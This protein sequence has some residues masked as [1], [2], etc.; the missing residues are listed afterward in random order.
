MWSEAVAR[1]HTSTT[2]RVFTGILS[3]PTGKGLMV[4]HIALKRI[5]NTWYLRYSRIIRQTRPSPNV[6]FPSISLCMVCMGDLEFVVGIV[7]G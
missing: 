7:K 2:E 1:T 5:V 6:P 4:R 3:I